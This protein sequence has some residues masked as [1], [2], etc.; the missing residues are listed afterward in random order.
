MTMPDTVNTTAQT[1]TVA[2]YRDRAGLAHRVLVRATEDGWEI[3]DVA[4]RLVDRLH[5]A[6]D[7]RDAAEALARAFAAEQRE[8][9]PR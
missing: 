5:A 4:T 9:S 7:D 3:L 1:S 8:R 6:Y 2:R